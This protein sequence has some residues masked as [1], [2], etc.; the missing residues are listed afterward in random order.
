MIKYGNFP[1]ASFRGNWDVNSHD[2]VKGMVTD[3]TTFITGGRS[4]LFH[5]T[6]PKQIKWLHRGLP[7]KA[8]TTYAVS[9]Y[10]KMENVKPGS[11]HGGLQILLGDNRNNYYPDTPYVG[12]M[13][14]TRQGFFWKT[15]KDGGRVIPGRSRCIRFGLRNAKGIVWIDN[16]KFVEV[17]QK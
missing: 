6:D 8:N 11:A 15:G 7:L 10:L 2:P 13:P 14:W 16:V 9:F 4:A 3:E 17:P 5:C 1:F 12:T